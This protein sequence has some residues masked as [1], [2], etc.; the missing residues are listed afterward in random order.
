MKKNE[1]NAGRKKKFKKG[2]ATFI[3]SHKMPKPVEKE[4]RKYIEDISKPFLNDEQI[5]SKKK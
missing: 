5:K 1:R 3:I 4:I 2:I